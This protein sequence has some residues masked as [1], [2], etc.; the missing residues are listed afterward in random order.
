METVVLCFPVDDA[1]VDA[2]RQRVGDANVIVS[3]QERIADDL[4]EATV[5]AAMPRFPCLWDEIV[6]RGKLKWIQS[7]AAGLDHCLVPS[8]VDSSIV[9]S[10][11][12]GLFAHQVAEQTMSLLFGLLRKLPTFFH[13]QQR[14]EYNRLPTDELQGKTVG[15]LGFGGNGR[16]IA[17]C[18]LPFDCQIIAT[19]CFAKHEGMDGVELFDAGETDDVIRRS[20]ILILTLPLLPETER[21]VDERRLA[22][23]LPHGSYVINVGRGRLLDE[24]A[25]VEALKEGRVAGGWT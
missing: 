15:I 5:F 24:S 3:S 14:H 10:G 17:R 13:A 21:Y 23:L 9:V 18:L 6:A 12:S 7:T 25:L 20:E 19:D 22:A 16:Q 2:I 8:V 11:C 1:Q 4:L